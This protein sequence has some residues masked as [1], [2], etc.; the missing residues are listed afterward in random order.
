M[1]RSIDC[2]PFYY[3]VTC[4]PLCPLSKICFEPSSLRGSELM[5]SLAK[6]ISTCYIDDTPKLMRHRSRTRSVREPLFSPE[7]AR[8]VDENYDDYEAS[9]QFHA[10]KSKP[11]MWSEAELKQLTLFLLLHTDGKTWIS[12]KNYKFW[13]SAGEFIQ[14]ILHTSHCRSGKLRYRPITH[15]VQCFICCRKNRKMKARN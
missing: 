12:H 13:D 6:S 2:Y 8:K 5:D 1:L 10:A 14:Q 9:E 3:L 7:A 11:T 4:A 15:V